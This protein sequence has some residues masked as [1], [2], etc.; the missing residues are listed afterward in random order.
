MSYDDN[1]TVIIWKG[2]PDSSPT[3]PPPLMQPLADI[4]Y[5]ESFKEFNKLE[6][7]LMK[8]IHGFESGTACST[9]TELRDV[10]D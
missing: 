10:F 3:L 6:P 5:V 4:F 8:Q 7:H 9:G 2:K 1:E